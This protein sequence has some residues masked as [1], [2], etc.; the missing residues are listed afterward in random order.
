MVN[1]RIPTKECSN[2]KCK[3]HNKFILDLIKKCMAIISNCSDEAIGVKHIGQSHKSGFMGWNNFVQPY[4]E[5]SIFGM[6]SGKV[7]AVLLLGS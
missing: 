3:A 7:L 2:F 6:I 4:K 1:A 5:K